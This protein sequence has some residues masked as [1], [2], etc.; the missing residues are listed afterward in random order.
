MGGWRDLTK[1]EIS[2]LRTTAPAW[3]DAST[4]NVCSA[5]R[6]PRSRPR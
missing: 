6:T 3:P 2:D 4:A 5:C 1:A